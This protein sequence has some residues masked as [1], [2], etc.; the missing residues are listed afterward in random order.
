MKI[1]KTKNVFDEALER[2]RFLFDEFP[3]IVI[4]MSG[5]KDSAVI[6]ELSR[7]VAREKG[8][9]PLKVFWLDQEC[10]FENTVKYIKGVM[11]D[12]DVIPL[13]YQIPFRLQNATSA[14]EQWLNCWGEGEEWVRPKDPISIKENTFG[15]DRFVALMEAIMSQTLD[16]PTAVLTGVRTEESPARFVALTEDPTYKWITWGNKIDAAKEIYNFH[17]LYDW[18]YLDVWKAIYEH[19]WAYNKHYDNLFRYG[20]P[21]RKMRVSNY[22]HETAVHSLFLLQEVEPATYERATQR[23]SGLDTAAKLG[24]DDWFVY[25]LPFMFQ[26]WVEYRDYLLE[27]LITD[28]KIREKF[29]KRFA[30][31][32]RRYSRSQ[33]PEMQKTFINSILCND[34]ELTKLANWEVRNY[35]DIQLEKKEKHEAEFA[36]YLAGG[37]E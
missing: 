2:I 28:P 10:E 17:P 37:S 14:N 11:Y 32:E 35:T 13:W 1:Y 33:G 30:S 21:V 5:G 9:L 31:I 15:V 7:I 20:V 18:T 25:D 27:K 26:D 6:F 22:F 3:E 29:A 8:R 24:Q 19:N 34:V 12:P 36:K 23:I 16:K 4:S